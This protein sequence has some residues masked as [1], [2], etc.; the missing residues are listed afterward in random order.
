MDQQVDLTAVEEGFVKAAKSYSERKGISYSTW[1][2][3]GVSADV[4]KR[5]GISRG[6]A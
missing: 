2:E 6:S 3:V 1:R 4:L 5:A